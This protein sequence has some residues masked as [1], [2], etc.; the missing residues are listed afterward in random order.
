MTQG[1]RDSSGGELSSFLHLTGWR[2]LLLAIVAGLA[3]AAGIFLAL[4][5]PAQFQARYVLNADLIA[6]NDATAADLSLFVQEVV[7]TASFPEVQDAVEE[8]TGLVFED[9]Y[10]LVVNQ[11]GGALININVVA[12]DPNDAN[13]VAIETGIE[14]ASITLERQNAGIES[15]R[16]QLVAEVNEDESRISELTV[17]AGGLN[18]RF[19]LDQ[20]EAALIQR[21]ADELNPPTQ[22]ILQPDGTTAVEE[23]PLDGPSASELEQQVAE[24]SPL[25]REFDTLQTQIAALQTTLSDRNNSI[26]EGDSAL[27]L[28]ETERETSLVIRNVV[29]EETSRISGL[30]T[31]LLLFAVPA[32]LI[33]I[34]LFTLLDLIRGRGAEVEPEPA[35]DF[36]PKGSI[37]PQEQRALPESTIRRSLTVVDENDATDV[38]GEDDYIEVV[39]KENG[40]DEDSEDDENKDEDSED[41]DSEDDENEET[42]AVDDDDD[43]PPTKS[44]NNTKTNGKKNG[45]AN[46]KN[47]SKDGRWGRE[48]ST[49]AG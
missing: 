5:E 48:A 16:D 21:R 45:K 20:A 15:S 46:G 49:K 12:A 6:D 36:E 28:L 40:R 1:E 22:A 30:L 32:A 31:G 23:I 44:T 29:T 19:A 17:L 18:P 33:M 42:A 25:A 8:R 43:E 37:E 3:G 9:D 34:L 10:E 13:E 39:A 2:P 38:L 27:V 24:L 4:Q 41:E 11:A 7:S 26:R 14:A 35:R 47:R